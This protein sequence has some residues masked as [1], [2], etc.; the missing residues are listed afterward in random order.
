[1]RTIKFLNFSVDPWPARGSPCLRAI[2][3]AGDEPSVPCQ[4][5]VRQGGS[6]HLAECLAK[7][8]GA[9][10]Y[11]VAV[12][13]KSNAKAAGDVVDAMKATGGKAVAMG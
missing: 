3:L 11:D 2:E 8:A 9:R 10:G 1:M 12:N 5:G 4:D 13:Y 7:L 6:R